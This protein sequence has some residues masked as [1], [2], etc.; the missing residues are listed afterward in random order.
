[1]GYGNLQKWVLCVGL[2]SLSLSELGG[3]VRAKREASAD[4]RRG[5]TRF[6]FDPA[7]NFKPD[8]SRPQF[9]QNVGANN[10]PYKLQP[11][12]AAGEI[13]TVFDSDFAFMDALY[14]LSEFA[15]GCLWFKTMASMN[16]SRTLSR[17]TMPSANVIRSLKS[18]NHSTFNLEFR[19]LYVLLTGNDETV[20][21]FDHHVTMD[22]VGARIG[23]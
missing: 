9:R 1:M 10:E 23:I 15:L 19:I 8:N 16:F 21:R 4:R 6:P 2:E 18:R 11:N 22:P 3:F 13:R 17:F 7:T 20:L 12:E 14:L 5:T